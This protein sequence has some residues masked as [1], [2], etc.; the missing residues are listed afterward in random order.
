MSF[1]LPG[2]IDDGPGTAAF[3]AEHVRQDPFPCR[4]RNYPPQNLSMEC[5]LSSIHRPEGSGSGAIEQF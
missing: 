3:A 1:N 4:Q 2:E 5:E